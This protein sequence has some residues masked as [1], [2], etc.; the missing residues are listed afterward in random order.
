[1]NGLETAGRHSLVTEEKCKELV[2]KLCCALGWKVVQDLDMPYALLK[3]DG[4]CG[5]YGHSWPGLLAN[6][7]SMAWRWCVPFSDGFSEWAKT[8]SSLEEF[9]VMIDLCCATREYGS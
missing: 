3:S 1:M 8:C 4:K 6:F 9:A 7:E 5:A 2:G